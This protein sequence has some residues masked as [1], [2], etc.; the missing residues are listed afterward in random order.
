MRIVR[1]TGSAFAGSGCAGLPCHVTCPTN[2]EL[3][4]GVLVGVAVGQL[5][6]SANISMVPGVMLPALPGH[7]YW[8]TTL[9][10]SFCAPIVTFGVSESTAVYTRSNL[11]W[12]SYSR[13]SK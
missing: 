1:V 5:Y 12:S 8:A 4:E 10:V 3:P 7:W 9:P 6:T 11:G 13:T 2:R